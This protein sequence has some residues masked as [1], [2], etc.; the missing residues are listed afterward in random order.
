M[1]ADRLVAALLFLQTRQRVTVAGPAAE[2]DVSERT[3]LRDPEALASSGIP[4]Y[5]RAGQDGGTR[6]GLAAPGTES[7]LEGLPGGRIRYGERAADDWAPF[8]A[9]GPPPR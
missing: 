2:M 4:V 8:E 5:S 6:P 1:R 7:I 3:A 9:D